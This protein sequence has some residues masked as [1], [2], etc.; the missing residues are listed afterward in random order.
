MAWNLLLFWHRFGMHACHVWVHFDCHFWLKRWS[1]IMPK[2]VQKRKPWADPGRRGRR[3]KEH[4]HLRVFGSSR[5][6]LTI[7]DSRILGYQDHG[8]QDQRTTGGLD[9]IHLTWWPKT[10]SLFLAAWWPPKGVGGYI[11]I[12]IERE[13]DNIYIRYICCNT[14]E[15]A[16]Q[17]SLH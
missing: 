10:G 8:L 14:W 1:N 13:R 12:Y 17:P 11:Y 5:P 6:P 2:H 4:G 15:Q 16:P 3:K 7:Q 9:G